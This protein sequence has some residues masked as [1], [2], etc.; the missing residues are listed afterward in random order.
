LDSKYQIIYCKINY[1]VK[2]KEK[3]RKDE[4]IRVEVE[5]EK[6][7]KNLFAKCIFMFIKVI[8]I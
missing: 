5:R 6:K 7:R 2:R 1:D 4:K 3:H 8:V